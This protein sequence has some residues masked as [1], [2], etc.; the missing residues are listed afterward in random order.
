M[1]SSMRQ[2]FGGW[3]CRERSERIFRQD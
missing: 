2:L 1:T 3:F